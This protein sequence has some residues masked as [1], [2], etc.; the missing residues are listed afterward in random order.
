[1][2]P[3]VSDESWRR[4]GDFDSPFNCSV[5]HDASINVLS[6]CIGSNLLV[7][8]FSDEGIHA[9]QVTFLGSFTQLG[10][11]KVKYLVSEYQFESHVRV[12]KWFYRISFW[13]LAIVLLVALVRKADWQTTFAN[14]FQI[15]LPLILALTFGWCLSF[16]CR[17][18]RFKSEWK[19]HADIPF[20][21]AFRLTVLHN[22]AVILVPLRVGELGY[23]VLVRKLI[24]VS[25]QQCI[26]SLLWLRFQDGFV[27]MA[28]VWLLLPLGSIQLRLIAL[29]AL[30]FVSL[31]TQKY[32]LPL[33]R[34]RHFLIG[35][36]RAFLHQRSDAWGW[37]WSLAN[38]SCKLLV[39]AIMLHQLT[40]LDVWQTFHG[41]LSGELSALLPLSGPAGLG[42]YEAGVWGGL[43]LPWSEMRDL[44][45]S[46]LLTHLFFLSISLGIAGFILLLDGLH[47]SIQFKSH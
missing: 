18:I 43:G 23:P 4:V 15:P 27:L 46:V 35:Q 2:E 7:P 45:S 40:G 1:L 36:L 13:I 44:M 42:T 32:W 33:L 47:S 31:G 25:W 8:C 26:R 20:S 37:L 28:F 34:S 5:S 10:D 29:V 39:V 38:W 16:V 24:H 3:L 9:D 22:A 11:Q 41:A 30:I 14:L 17:A 19:R 12:R 21:A 6:G